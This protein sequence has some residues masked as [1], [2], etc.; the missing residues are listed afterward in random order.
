MNKLRKIVT[1]NFCVW[2][3]KWEEGGY[4]LFFEFTNCYSILWA[5]FDAYAASP[6]KDIVCHDIP[7]VTDLAFHPVLGIGD[8]DRGGAV[9]QALSAVEGADALR[10]I[11]LNAYGALWDFEFS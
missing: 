11:Y 4:V 2:L 6:A 10:F 9:F 3:Q 1:K 7:V 8:E 5:G